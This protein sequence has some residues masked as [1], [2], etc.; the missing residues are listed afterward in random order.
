MA[1]SYKRQVGV[2]MEESFIHDVYEASENQNKK[3]K[4]LVDI[5]KNNIRTEKMRSENLQFQLDQ[6]NEALHSKD[7]IISTLQEEIEFNKR[8]AEHMETRLRDL[9]LKI[10]NLESINNHRS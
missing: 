1:Q 2:K 5:L 4:E 8:N 9:A 3:L 7:L 6:A 10:E